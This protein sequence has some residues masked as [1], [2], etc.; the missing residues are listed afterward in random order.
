MTTLG[1]TGSYGDAA[2]SAAIDLTVGLVVKGASSKMFGAADDIA[3]NLT[4]ETGKR[5][6][7]EQTR[8]LLSH[9]ARAT[10]EAALSKARASLRD[11]Q[12][13]LQESLNNGPQ[14][15]LAALL[16]E[17]EASEIKAATAVARAEA[18]SIEAARVLEKREEELQLSA[19]KRQ[20]VTNGR[21]SA[22]PWT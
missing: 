2:A 1:E 10:A 12:E 7:A 9:K 20:Q 13:R 6:T 21:N 16:A 15:A 17:K 8:Q 14:A 11:T 22:F 4:R 19:K 5:L 3:F 18:A